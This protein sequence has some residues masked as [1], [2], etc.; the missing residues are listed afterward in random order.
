MKNKLR[1]YYVMFFDYFEPTLH[2]VKNPLTFLYYAIF[3]KRFKKSFKDFYL[4]SNIKYARKPRRILCTLPRSG[5]G[6]IHRVYQSVLML[7]EGVRGEFAIKNNNYESEIAFDWFPSE[8][9]NYVSGIGKIDGLQNK[10]LFHKYAITTCHHPIQNAD[11]VDINHPDVTPC[12]TM[13]DIF[14]CLRSWAFFQDIPPD[15][16][17][18]DNDIGLEYFHVIKHRL[19][20]IISHYNYWGK[21]IENKVS[22]KDYLCV[23]YEELSIN[24]LQEFKKIFDFYEIYINPEILS[25]AVSEHSYE[26]TVN[27][28]LLGHKKPE[29]FMGISIKSKRKFNDELNNKIATVIND[30][31]RYDFDYNY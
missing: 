26:K 1:D 16:W 28:V 10:D 25:S 29:N 6:H 23:K 5:S 4:Y 12:F 17:Y 27:K 24:P 11:L 20:E 21:Y 22:G 19:N 31:L 13:R 8:L 3:L 14:D 2:N 9:R 18:G 7:I 30:K 15:E